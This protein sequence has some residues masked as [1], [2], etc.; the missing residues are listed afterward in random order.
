MQFTNTNIILLKGFLGFAQ[1][2]FY[3][4]IM[5]SQYLTCSG[6]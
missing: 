2:V 5:I 1:V 6:Q 3:D 4:A